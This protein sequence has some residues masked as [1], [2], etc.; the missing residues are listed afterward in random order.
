MNEINIEQQGLDMLQFV[1]NSYPEFNG[2]CK[3]VIGE[4]IL[5]AILNQ[6]LWSQIY[7]ASNL[8]QDHQ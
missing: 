8:L 3:E 7:G 4:N 6:K 5:N 1:G 2:R